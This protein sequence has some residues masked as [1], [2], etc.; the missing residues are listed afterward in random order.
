MNSRGQYSAHAGNQVVFLTSMLLTRYGRL[1][2]CDIPALKTPQSNRKYLTNHLNASLCS[3]WIGSETG[4]SSTLSARR[5]ETVSHPQSGAFQGAD[6][7]FE[8]EDTV[9]SNGN[10]D[11]SRCRSR[12]T[13]LGPRGEC[14]RPSVCCEWCPRSY[15]PRAEHIPECGLFPNLEPRQRTNRNAYTN[16]RMPWFRFFSFC[17][18]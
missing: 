18:C 7:S 16:S 5:L 17:I 13:F 11:S 4:C 10:G 6:P 12:T 15:K 1:V 14:D 8:R 2:R 9:E 3:G